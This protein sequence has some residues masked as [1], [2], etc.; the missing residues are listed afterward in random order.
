MNIQ[1]NIELSI[2]PKQLQAMTE[3]LT[4]LRLQDHK[5]VYVED[6]MVFEGDIIVSLDDDKFPPYHITQEGEIEESTFI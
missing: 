2:T 1:L 3:L 6:S 5:T 4:V